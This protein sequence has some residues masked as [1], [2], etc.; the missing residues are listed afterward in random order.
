[1][2]DFDWKKVSEFLTF[3]NLRSFTAWLRLI[4]DLSL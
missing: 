1:M 3:V 2:T 4:E